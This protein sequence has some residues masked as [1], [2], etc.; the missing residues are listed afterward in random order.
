MFKPKSKLI[1][2]L[3]ALTVAM[4][5][6]ASASASAASTSPS[7]AFTDLPGTYWAKDAIDSLVQ[8]GVVNGFEDRTFKPQS[9]V[10]REQF[11]QL[12]T[13]S[14]YLDLP[15][16]PSQSF[17]DVSPSRWSYPAVESAKEFLTGY[18]PPSGRAFFNPT[19]K[20]TREDVA[21]AL[22]KTLGYQPDE[23]ENK[24]ILTRYYDSDEI[25]PGLET[26]LALA[27]EKKL[28]TGYNDY[29]LKP[30][31]PVTRAEAAALLYRVMK[32]AAGDSQQ[33]LSLQVNAPATTATSTFYVSGTVTKGAKVFLNSTEAEVEQGQFR[34]ALQLDEEGTYTYTVTARMPGG[35]SQIVTKEINYEKGAPT[36]TVSGVPEQTDKES[37]TV[38]WK[39]T[40]PNDS[41]PTIYVNGQKQSSFS[42]S[43]TVKLSEGANVITVR[44]E[45]RFGKSTEV[46]KTAVLSLGGPSLNVSL[47]ETT[48]KSRAVVSWTVSDKNDS[49]P[50]VYVNGQEQSSFQSSASLELKQGPNTIVVRAENK[51]GKSTTVTRVITFT[52]AGPSLRLEETAAVVDK[53]KLTVSWS[54]SD[55]NDS[56]PRVTLNGQEMSSYSSSAQVALVPGSNSIRLVATN[57][58]GQKT[59]LTREVQ[60][61][62]A[63]PTL[64][65]GYA[66][67]T[68]TAQ[69]FTL[70]WTVSDLNDSQPKVYVNDKLASS[71][72]NS[73]NVKL[74]SGAN[75]FRFVASN[76]FGLSSEKTITIT[77][78]PEAAAPSSS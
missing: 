34:V 62:P 18:Y 69:E 59:E 9:P 2:G 8:L 31:D 24:Q 19:G 39:A 71:Y 6:L 13:L 44:A 49:S 45:N 68:T 26:Y 23:L 74:Q 38:S 36:L 43:A 54:V 7:P 35:K 77:Y 21:V 25:S 5:S 37:I 67:E 22:V 27:V 52:S 78:Q 16:N 61:Q 3:L 17:A 15:E 10:T 12:V 47:P 63:A 46:V 56:S 76:R 65:I 57:K 14:F 48:D 55:L 33:A 72:S 75:T 58:L 11:A 41:S 4:P 29:T 73:W 66:P 40:D 64:S 20:A 51:Q 32:S 70:T 28:L 1:L 53:E 30:A 50:K 42:E 60:F